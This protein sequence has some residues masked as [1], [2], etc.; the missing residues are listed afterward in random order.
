MLK[1][2]NKGTGA[3]GAKTNLYG[4]KFED[5]TNNEIRLID[6]DFKLNNISSKKFG[7]CL[8]KKYD[9]KE[10]IFVIQ[11]GLKYYMKK[12]YDITIFRNPDEAYI[13]KYDNG[14]SIIKILEKKEQNVEGSVETKLWSSPS[15]KRE[16]EILLGDKFKVDYALCVNDYLQ[17][18]LLSSN[19]KYIIL[20]KILNE[21]NIKILFGNDELYYD[22]LDKWINNF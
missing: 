14:I 18:K 11:S 20:N 9:D 3:G 1:I 22:N 10:V 17:N 15:L 7:Y 5:L 12:Y 6:N 13:I 16:Y 21:N 2:M 4:K 19:N 8:S